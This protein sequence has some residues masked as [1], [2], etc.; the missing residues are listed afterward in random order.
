ME[1]G[2][3]V[4]LVWIGLGAGRQGGRITAPFPGGRGCLEVPHEDDRG[5]LL[6]KAAVAP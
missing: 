1:H 2:E 6:H 3:C 4:G 5:S